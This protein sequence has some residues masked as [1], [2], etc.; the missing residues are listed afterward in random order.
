MSGFGINVAKL[1]EA[2]GWEMN[3]ATHQP[4]STSTKMANV[5]GLVL[6]RSQ[7]PETRMAE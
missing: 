3:W 6:I 4:D 5:C 2:A 7:K 1:F